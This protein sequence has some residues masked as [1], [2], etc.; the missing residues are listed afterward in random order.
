[1]NYFSV[2]LKS[3]SAWTTLKFYAGEKVAHLVVTSYVRQPMRS[4]YVTWVAKAGRLDD[5]Y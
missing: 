2:L 5:N 4:E 3:N 1:M